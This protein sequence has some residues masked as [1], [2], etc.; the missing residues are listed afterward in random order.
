MSDHRICIYRQP[1]QL[2]I[3]VLRRV[4]TKNEGIE[5]LEKCLVGRDENSPGRTRKERRGATDFECVIT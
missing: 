3:S 1:L 5:D 2:H 4:T